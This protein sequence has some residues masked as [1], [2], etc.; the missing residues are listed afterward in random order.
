MYE[1]MASV[2]ANTIFEQ[3]LQELFV[4]GSW[5]GEILMYRK[6][7]EAFPVL[8]SIGVLKD[9]EGKITG[10]V[11][12]IRD[13]TEI[14]QLEKKLKDLNEEL[15][16]R[17]IQ[18]T[19]ELTNVFDR[20]SDG[21]TAFDADWNYTYIN[22]K[23]AEI[24]HRDPKEII[25]KNIWQEFPEIVETSLYQKYHKAMQ[26]QQVLRTEE[27]ADSFQKW[28]EGVLYPSP[29]GLSLYFHDITEQKRV[30]EALLISQKNYCLLFEENPV[31]L[32]M[33]D[34]ETFAFIDINHAAVVQYGYS[35]E[36]FTGM[37]A[38]EIK[39]PEE[40]SFLQI[41]QQKSKEE[42]GLEE[43]VQHRKKNGDII[44]VKITANLIVFNK[45]E[46]WLVAGR[47]VTQEFFYEQ[48]IKQS[49]QQLSLIFNSTENAIWLLKVEANN[50]FRV[51]AVNEAFASLGGVNKEDMPGRLLDEIFDMNRFEN[52]NA[53]YKACV[54]SGVAQKFTNTLWINKEETTFDFTISPIKDE[55][56]KVTQLLGVSADVTER[57][58]AQQLIRESA[59]KYHVLFEKSPMP[60]WI[61]DTKTLKFLE[62][63]LAAIKQ[64]GYSREE[65]LSMSLFD[66][67]PKKE[68][69]E[70]AATC[71]EGWPETVDFYTLHQKK[72]GELIIVQVTANLLNYE[73]KPARMAIVIDRT[74]QEEARDRLIDTT[75][76]L[77][78]LA[79]HL[80]DI[81]EEERTNIA[82]EIHDEL[83]QQLTALKM[84]IAWLSRKW[85][86]ENE[87]IRNKIK[88]AIELADSTINTVRK[89]AAQLR[90][91][92]LDDLGL[93]EAIAWQSSE[94]TS[95]TGIVVN[96]FTDVPDD[97]FSP[98]VSTAVFRIFQEALTNIAR[99]ARATE[100]V[101]QLQNKNNLLCL[102]VKDNGIGFDIT[103][104]AKRKTLG[105]LGMK[106]RAIM[107]NGKYC[108]ESKPGE[109]TKVAVEIPLEE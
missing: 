47:D 36:E 12:V 50:C 109:G 73:N 11:S 55:Q 20:I 80:Q 101:C 21:F 39:V 29:E 48:N 98:S 16:Q 53:R 84:D 38:K 82:R 93:A 64:Y 102:V 8:I 41:L 54:E 25:G 4:K 100:V 32:W 90:P 49:Q 37:S 70:L 63:N 31:P 57:K 17:V 7:G 56:G 10:T 59:E 35:K 24:I 52:V 89:I 43:V 65:F 19:E 14:K 72:N 92:M 91:S 87:S 13:I 44:Y 15:E 60:N 81:R 71:R 88:S 74:E 40:H 27:Y 68:A 103:G 23:A 85:N 96:C 107:L 67:R 33:T 106:E 77:R 86:T 83:G 61:F 76:Q 34:A 79:S 6:N 104:Q 30:K 108:I 26:E 94:F 58:K 28:F 2:N 9:T 69:L 51:L 45:R 5:K 105:L 95:R 97:K 18:K 66:I 3:T 99:H 1:W 75:Q 42:K 22:K 46:V 78:E 62:V